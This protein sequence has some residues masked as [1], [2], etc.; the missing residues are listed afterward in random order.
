MKESL[1]KGLSEE[2]IARIRAYKNQEKISKVAKEK[3]TEP[4]DEQLESVSGGCKKEHE[5]FW[6]AGGTCP[7]C[8]SANTET[9]NGTWTH[10]A[11]IKCFACIYDTLC[12]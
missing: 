1:L 8:G 4:F 10:G 7:K 5:S 9:Y 11:T 3:D 2:Q 6:Y 12:Q